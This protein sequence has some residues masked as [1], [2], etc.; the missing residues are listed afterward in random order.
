[1]EDTRREP[2]LRLMHLTKTYGD[3][4]AVDDLSLDVE[5]GEFVCLLGPSGC[6]KTT[7]LRI[8]AGLEQPNA[9]EIRQGGK[10]I[11]RLPVRERDFGIVF[12]SFAL[13]PNLTAEQNIAYG[14]VN[15]GWA[16][17]DI[18]ARV[19]RLM[20]LMDLPDDYRSKYPSQLSG[21][22]Q[23]RVALA[24]ALAPSPGLLL[25]DEPLSSLD[26]KV[27]VA[28][29]LEIKHMQQAIG[30]TTIHVTHDQ[31]EALA[32]GDR[33]VVMN[34]GH[35]EQVASPVDLYCSPR[36]P[37]V[38]DFVG[39]TNFLRGYAGPGPD[40]VRCGSLTLHCGSPHGFA[41]DAPVRLSIRPEDARLG[42]ADPATLNALH[43]EVEDIE[44]LGSFYR[45]R[46]QVDGLDEGARV[47]VEA[48]T[49]RVRD[50]SLRQGSDLAV[51]LPPSLLRVYPAE[52]GAR[53]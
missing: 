13:F 20:A 39:I 35:I 23:Q 21:G 12:Q 29:R 53:R 4:V 36:T 11:T 42:V 15:E 28:L 52:G 46:L 40:E 51:Q 45:L 22:E 27:R 14:L 37:F 30:V 47:M 9:G 10:E 2:Y 24:R 33:V 17:G 3:L 44:F 34:Q 6:G 5:E 43:A 7:T 32:I 31:E 50:L 1:M 41:T 19:D 38:A 25:L 26:A 49:N 16:K 48:S 8:I 18:E